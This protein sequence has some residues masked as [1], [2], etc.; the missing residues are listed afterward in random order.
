MFFQSKSDKNSTIKKENTGFKLSSV[1]Q[2]IINDRI[3]KLEIHQFYECVQVPS[4][5][6][7][8]IY[9]FYDNII[10]EIYILVATFT[11]ML[12]FLPVWQDSISCK[13]ISSFGLHLQSDWS[14]VTLDYFFATTFHANNVI[15][16]RHVQQ[17]KMHQHDQK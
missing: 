1:K 17:F 13:K 11:L 8:D 10:I 3:R 7:N 14:C 9:S 16:I 12:V 6:L 4:S 2:I 5:T 15:N